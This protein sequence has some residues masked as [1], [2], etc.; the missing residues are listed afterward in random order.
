MSQNEKNIVLI[1]FMGTGKS[2]VGKLLAKKLN[3]QFIDTDE[4]IENKAKISIKEIFELHGETHFREMEKFV[5]KEMETSKNTVISTGGGVVLDNEN[6][7]KLASIGTII[8]LKSNPRVIYKRTSLMTNRPLLNEN[9]TLLNG[10]NTIVNENTLENANYALAAIIEK[11]ET[12]KHLYNGELNLDTSFL[13]VEEA[14]DRII[15]YVSSQTDLHTLKVE[16]SSSDY[17]IVIGGRI[18]GILPEKIK[19]IINSGQVLLVTSENVA[20]LWGDKILKILLEN[21]INAS[22]IKLPDG[23]ENKYFESVM[24]IYDAAL[25]KKLGR[26]STIIAVGGGMIGDIAGFAASTYMRGIKLIQIPTTLLAQVD[27]A[28]GGKTGI[29]HLS[30]KNMIGSFYQPKLVFTDTSILTTLPNQEFINGL[31]EVVKYGMILD[32]KLFEFLEKNV[33]GILRFEQ[34]ILNQIVKKCSYIKKTIV[35]KDE[36]ELGIRALL[37]YGH[38]IGH[39]IEAATD[40]TKYRHGEAVSIGMIFAGSIALNRRL[41]S[42]TDFLRQKSILEAFGL[43]T[44]LE[45]VDIERILF[46]IS[47]D[48][49]N[50]YGKIRMALPLS[51]GSAK[52]YDD[53]KMAELNCLLKLKSMS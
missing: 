46:A 41:L 5:I 50:F 38:T 3:F 52:I 23:E 37:N 1:G 39:A 29:N 7:K 53:I 9:Y 45:N 48:K 17:E 43:P 33:D 49:K 6:I 25:D 30:G 44:K 10:N 40:Y 31:A 16:T 36:K 24:K 19:P 51:I 27:S 4:M 18:F 11:L 21:E 15:S 8:C 13:S 34:P 26:T 47:V 42:E 20:S 2:S 32:N 12:R 35:E 22:M 28:I 14:V